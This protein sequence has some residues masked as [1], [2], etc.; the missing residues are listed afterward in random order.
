MNAFSNLNFILDKVKL[1]KDAKYVND[2]TP[3]IYT[4]V[5]GDI[6]RKV[7]IHFIIKTFS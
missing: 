2:A 5:V 3:D 1:S 4:G 7:F 6:M